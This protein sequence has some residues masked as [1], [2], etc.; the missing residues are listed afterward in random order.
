[1]SKDVCAFKTHTKHSYSASWGV[2]LFICVFAHWVLGFCWGVC[3]CSFGNRLTFLTVI[4]A[5]AAAYISNANVII[6]AMAWTFSWRPHHVWT[7]VVLSMCRF[8]PS[9]FL[10]LL[11]IVPPIVLLEYYALDYRQYRLDLSDSKICFVD[12]NDRCASQNVTDDE[13]SN[14]VLTQVFMVLLLVLDHK[15]SVPMRFCPPMANYVHISDSSLFWIKSSS[16]C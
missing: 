1:M 2:C 8:L 11:W 3:L 13:T 6:G 12:F 7:P 15:D 9:V 4:K 10:Y 16:P 14:G 5:K